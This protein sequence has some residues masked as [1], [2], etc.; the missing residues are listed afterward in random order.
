MNSAEAQQVRALSERYFQEFGW[1]PY[2]EL[3]WRWEHA[4]EI[5]WYI[6]DE[7][8]GLVRSSTGLFIV[9]RKA[10]KRDWSE[11]VGQVWI[12]TCWKPPMEEEEWQSEPARAR[13]PWPQHGEYVPIESFTCNEGQVPDQDL[14]T[15][16]AF[17]I[18]EHLR[19]ID[20]KNLGLTDGIRQVVDDNLAKIAA[21]KKSERSLLETMLNDEM[22]AFGKIPGVEDGGIGLGRG[23]N[24]QGFLDLP[25]PLERKLKESQTNERIN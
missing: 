10:E 3:R 21:Q 12:L 20:Q 17:C 16:A 4:T 19:R 23:K 14:S 11:L 2:G 24:D 7:S 1:N 6:M 18:R 5:P 9:D 22:T 13:F 8:A 25:T 15:R